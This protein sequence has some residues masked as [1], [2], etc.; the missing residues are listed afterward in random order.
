MSSLSKA[1]IFT[2]AILALS[3]LAALG[4]VSAS[5]EKANAAVGR[6]DESYLLP[7]P[8]ALRTMSLGYNEL[9]A[10]LVWIQALSY[11][12][13]QFHARGEYQWLDRYIETVVA[14]DPEFRMIYHW[15]GTVTMYDGR[16][17][18]NDSV[19]SSIRFLEM[20]IEQY[21]DD[22]F[23]SFMAGVNYRFELHTNDPEERTLWHERG[24]DLIARAGQQP[25]AP[26]WLALA[27]RN[28]YRRNAESERVNEL[29]L[30]RFATR[31]DLPTATHR[32]TFAALQSYPSL[33]RRDARYLALV[34]AGV[35][36]ERS[37]TTMQWT[38]QL[39]YRRLRTLDSDS[40]FGFFPWA[41]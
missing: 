3:S 24:A 16:E 5:I 1:L 22:W 37:A 17:I 14:L 19:W 20:G 10:D 8:G 2:A 30:S 25:E 26:A 35:G 28:T 4:R 9:A 21:P 18:D 39:Q 12:A 36:L 41:P 6:L 38:E 32:L 11:F 29:N 15:A 40:E 27:A 31:D 7:E 33:L 13:V 23:L 34:N